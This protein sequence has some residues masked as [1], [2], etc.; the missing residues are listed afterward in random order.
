MKSKVIVALDTIQQDVDEIK[1]SN[2]T[3]EQ[4][5]FAALYYIISTLQNGIA[6]ALRRSI[7]TW[8]DPIDHTSNYMRHM[9]ERQ[10]N[11]GRWFIDG[12]E[13]IQWKSNIDKFG[14]FWLRG[15]SKQL[16]ISLL[17]YQF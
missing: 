4:S 15:G 11:T 17:S 14:F 5:A 6:E 12:D 3:S 8:L 9:N 2:E 13:F 7:H 1:T 10:E 16:S